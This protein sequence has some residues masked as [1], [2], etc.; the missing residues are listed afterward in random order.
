[1]NSQKCFKQSLDYL[2]NGTH[3]A[4]TLSQTL[5]TCLHVE[6]VTVCR[7]PGSYSDGYEQFY[8]LGY[9]AVLPPSDYM[10]FRNVR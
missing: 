9:N 3:Y 2:V 8:L 1:M 7:I 6:V 10:F 4:A 5:R